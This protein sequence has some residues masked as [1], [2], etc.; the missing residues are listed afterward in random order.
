[1]RDR[2]YIFYPAPAG[3]KWHTVDRITG[4]ASCHN[5]IMDTQTRLLFM[6][7]P[8]R[9]RFTRSFAAV[10]WLKSDPKH[11]QNLPKKV[12]VIVPKIRNTYLTKGA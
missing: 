7:A 8:T 12:L 1:M 11:T 6:S 3:G 5:A 9:T 10:A 2:T 4:V